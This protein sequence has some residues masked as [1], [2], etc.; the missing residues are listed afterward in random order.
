M[1]TCFFVSLRVICVFDTQAVVIVNAR[2]LIPSF[3]SAS[4]WTTYLHVG[5]PPGDE[6]KSGRALNTRIDIRLARRKQTADRFYLRRR[7]CYY[8][9]V[10]T[11]GLLLV[12]EFLRTIQPTVFVYRVM[13][14]Y[15]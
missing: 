2:A 8:R 10:I 15:P 13:E 3:F 5:R 9:R 14:D 1:S 6:T 11:V 4:S 7:V 12:F